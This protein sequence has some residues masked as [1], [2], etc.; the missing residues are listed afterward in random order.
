M[1]GENRVKISSGNN[2]SYA[3]RVCNNLASLTIIL[4]AS[5]K[6]YPT[7]SFGL[8]RATTTS[9]PLWVE[10]RRGGAFSAAMKICLT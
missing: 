1:A 7:N 4:N 9:T 6:P 10:W 3:T 8:K 5:S 2:V